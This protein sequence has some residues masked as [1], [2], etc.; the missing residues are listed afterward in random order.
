MDHHRNLQTRCLQRAKAI[1]G[2]VGMPNV[3]VFASGGQTPQQARQTRPP[4][5]GHRMP[6]R[7]GFRLCAVPVFAMCNSRQQIGLWQGACPLRKFQQVLA[8]GTL[9]QKPANSTANKA[10]NSGIALQELLQIGK[11]N[12]I[13][14]G[15]DPMAQPRYRSRQVYKPGLWHRLLRGF[16]LRHHVV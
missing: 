16:L 11:F 9:Q 2:Q 7:R 13:N 5:P 15:H 1:C 14:T 4:R 12:P 6:A 10:K 8:T 3:E